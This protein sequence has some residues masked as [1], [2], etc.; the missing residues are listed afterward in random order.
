MVACEA[1][2]TLAGGVCSAWEE[3]GV[4]PEGKWTCVEVVVVMVLTR[5]GQGKQKEHRQECKDG[6]KCL[7]VVYLAV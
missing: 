6:G 7:L 3:W 4:Y 2:Q 1:R 5:E